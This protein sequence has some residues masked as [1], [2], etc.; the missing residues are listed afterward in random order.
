MNLQPSGRAHTVFNF[1]K[2]AAHP[3]AN[4]TLLPLCST[5]PGGVLVQDRF[6]MEY[7]QAQQQEYENLSCE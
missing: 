5:S 2:D 6:C 7:P 1:P 3:A 4:A